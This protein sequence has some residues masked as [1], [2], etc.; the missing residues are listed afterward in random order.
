MLFPNT[1]TKDSPREDPAREEPAIA[2]QRR[3]RRHQPCCHFDLK[4]LSPPELRENA[5]LLFKLPS[6]WSFI[7]AT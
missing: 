1:G 3:S 2:Q 5:Y 6:L 4:L 7:M